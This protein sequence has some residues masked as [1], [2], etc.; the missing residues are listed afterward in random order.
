MSPS[1]TGVAPKQSLKQAEAVHLGSFPV[2]EAIF[3]RFLPKV[4]LPS[5]WDKPASVLVS[6]PVHSQ[7]VA[8]L[9]SQ[10]HTNLWWS[11][12]YHDRQELGS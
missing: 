12:N 4:D 10:P 11:P 2:S 9:T 6:I 1:G 7:A 3:R 5:A 8:S